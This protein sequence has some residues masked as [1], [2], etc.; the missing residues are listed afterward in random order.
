MNIY[1]DLLDA[2]LP[3]KD[4]KNAA[5][6]AQKAALEAEDTSR[7]P[8][9]MMKIQSDA[10][11]AHIGV[12]NTLPGDEDSQPEPAKASPSVTPSSAKATTTTGDF[13]S[14]EKAYYDIRIRANPNVADRTQVLQRVRR[15]IKQS[16]NM[17]DGYAKLI[18]YIKKKYPNDSQAQ[19]LK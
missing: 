17:Q 10:H 11:Q 14:L 4:A 12:N 13:S 8:A 2:G 5:F 18:A 1:K 19:S 15:H 9:I 16:K 7:I 3:K 6:A